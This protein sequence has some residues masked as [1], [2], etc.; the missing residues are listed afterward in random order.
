MQKNTQAAKEAH[1]ELRNCK[2][3]I[4]EIKKF[5]QNFA[6]IKSHD[7][8]NLV[9]GFVSDRDFRIRIYRIMKNTK[10][11]LLFFNTHQR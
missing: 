6:V 1:T 9:P 3:E 8:A 11:K 5:N 4:K 10:Q 2:Q 7:P